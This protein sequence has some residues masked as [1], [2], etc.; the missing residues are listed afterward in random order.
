MELPENL[1]ETFA[2]LEAQGLNPEFCDTPVPYFDAGIP[3]G[4]PREV[5]EATPDGYILVPRSLVGNDAT[6]IA[7]VTGDSMKNPNKVEVIDER[8]PQQIAE[9]IRALNAESQQLLDEI[10]AML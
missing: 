9:E 4:S 8:T 3:C 2:L 1:K 6:V 5:Y 10:L 7:R